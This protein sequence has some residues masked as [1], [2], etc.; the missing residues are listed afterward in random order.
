MFIDLL[1]SL[2]EDLKIGLLLLLLDK[3]TNQLE[4]KIFSKPVYILVGFMVIFLSQRFLFS[5]FLCLKLFLGQHFFKILFSSSNKTEALAYCQAPGPGKVSSRS[6]SCLVTIMRS[7]EYFKNSNLGF[8]L[9]SLNTK[10]NFSSVFSNNYVPYL[11]S[12]VQCQ[13][14]NV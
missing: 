13:R 9:S 7:F 8:F 6:R 14:S 12:N 1:C 2:D 10:N 11:M 3:E 4:F 5:T